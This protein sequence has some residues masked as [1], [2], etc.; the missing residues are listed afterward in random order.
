MNPKL[1]ALME[2]LKGSQAKMDKIIDQATKGNNG[3]EFSKVTEIGGT[4]SE[5]AATFRAL[6][7]ECSATMIEIETERESLKVIDD[8]KKRAEIVRNFKMPGGKTGEGKAETE[9]RQ[10]KSL[11]DAFLEHGFNL[12]ENKGKEINIEGVSLKTLMDE[13]TNG[14]VPQSLRT[15]K[16]VEK[17]VRPIQVIDLIPAGQTDMIAV[18][19]MQEDTIDESQVAETDEA[20]QYGETA[21]DYSE[22]SSLVRKIAVFLPVTDEQLE[23]VAQVRGLINNRLPAMI[24]RKLDSQLVNGLGTGVALRGMLNVVGIQTYARSAVSG[25]LA[26]DA[27]RRAM[28]LIHTGAFSVANGVVMYPTDWE[29]IRLMKTTQGVY[30]W[31][32]PAEV[33][34]DRVWGLPVAQCDSIAAGTAIVADFQQS[35]L[36][37]K[38]GISVLTSNSHSDFFIKGKQAVRADGRWAFIVYRPA[39]FVSVNLA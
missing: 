5:K 23:D 16:L 7:D 32:H 20:A 29:G 18:K 30:V 37:E 27:L 34:M 25:D 31:G 12:P 15:G 38:R 2:K 35:E 6:N 17:A 21:F 8:N 11:G 28:T 24:M 22:Q 3:L 33:G 4:D 26:V 9:A 36:A 13:V 14:W 1:K 19:Y 10:Y 39:A